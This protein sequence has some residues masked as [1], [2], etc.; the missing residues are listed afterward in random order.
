MNIPYQVS[1]S[2]YKILIA[3]LKMLK[4]KNTVIDRQ[5]IIFE[6]GVSKQLLYSKVNNV[7]IKENI[8]RKNSYE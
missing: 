2:E 4:E 5:S 6:S 7:Y 8:L 3:I 1:K